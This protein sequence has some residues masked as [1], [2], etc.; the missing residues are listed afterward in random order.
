MLTLAGIGPTSALLLV[1]LL[2]ICLSTLRLS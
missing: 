2:L 1:D